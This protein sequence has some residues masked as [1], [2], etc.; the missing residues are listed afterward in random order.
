[1]SN[2][3][4][5]NIATLYESVDDIDL[6][7]AGISEFPL[8]GAQVG[9]TFACIIG[10]QMQN[11]RAADRFW[12]ESSLGPHAFTPSQLESIKQ[13]SLARLI[14]ANSDSIISIQQ[15]ALQLAH[16]ILNP[17]LHCDELPDVDISL[18]FEPQTAP[19]AG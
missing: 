10:R 4:A 15:L 13:V 6:F 16:P 5:Q 2:R 7:S 1:M 14:C 9:P 12:F 17:R 3:S 8:E 11:L 19:G 18:W